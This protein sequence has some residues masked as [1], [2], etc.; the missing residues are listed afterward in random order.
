VPKLS[1]DS[2]NWVVYQDRMIWAM[3]SRGLTDHLT[4]IT[5]PTTYG[6]VGTVRRLMLSKHW[7][8]SEA[9]VK[10]TLAALVPD[11]IFNQIKGS[12][13]AKDAWDTLKAL[14]E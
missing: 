14:F 1:A 10:Q 9:T 3:D 6:S 5:K 2:S 13:R 7:A 11:S 8:L 12:A 4:N